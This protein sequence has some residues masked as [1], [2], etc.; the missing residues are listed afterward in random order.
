MCPPFILPETVTIQQALQSA[1]EFLSSPLKSQAIDPHVDAKLLLCHVIDQHQTYLYTWPD[2][3]LSESQQ[4]LFVE[5]ITKRDLGH[6]VSYLTGTRGFWTLNLKTDDSTL[7]PRADT[8]CMVECAISLLPK[9]RAK[10]LDLGVGTGAIALAI[11]S[12]NSQW[13]VYG[14]DNNYLALSLAK[15]NIAYCQPQ[16]Q[17][18]QI[19]IVFSNWFSYFFEQNIRDFDLIISNPPYIAK[20]DQHLNLGDVAFEPRSALVAGKQGYADLYHIIDNSS[21]FLNDSGI[22]MV[23]HGFEQGAMVR[24]HFVQRGFTQVVTGQDLT[25]NDRYTFGFA[26]NCSVQSE[27]I[28]TKAK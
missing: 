13:Q 15:Q 14:C 21:H 19:E 17:G 8:E 7:I 12:E 20:D 9:K 10:I 2:R 6:P 22:L 25:G 27:E 24:K 4:S 3:Y 11:A 23:E 1:V 16:L 28:D 18:A 5:L 26:K